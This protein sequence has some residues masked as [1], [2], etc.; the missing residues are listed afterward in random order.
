M[1]LS[2][3]LTSKKKK[4]KCVA[5][6]PL[7]DAQPSCIVSVCSGSTHP[8]LFGVTGNGRK[9]PRCCWII[10]FFFFFFF[11]NKQF[12]PF[13]F[14]LFPPRSNNLPKTNNR[15]K[16]F[17]KPL[18]KPIPPPSPSFLTSWKYGV[19]KSIR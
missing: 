16:H 6:L 17:L 12:F 8:A 15:P 4:G 18:E 1:N 19:N 13:L 10:F 14:T 2:R 5:T 7:N 3:I 9:R 11:L